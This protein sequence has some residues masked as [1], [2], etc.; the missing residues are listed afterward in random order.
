MKA[1]TLARLEQYVRPFMTRR[2]PQKVISTYSKGRLDF[3][4]KFK[5]ELP[6]K[7]YTPPTH[8]QQMLWGLRFQ[9][10]IMNSA[11]MFKNAE[12]YDIVLRQGAGAY[13]GGT[14]TWNARDGN[15]KEGIHLPFVPYPRSHSASNW[16]GLPN[17]GD[18]I[19]S[20][21]VLEMT[22][23]EG[24][25]IGWSLMGSPDFH[26]EE[27][28]ANLVKGMKLYEQAGV[29]FLEI[30]ESCP[31]TA[32]SQEEGLAQRLGYIKDNFLNKRQRQLPVIVKFSNDTPVEQIP[33]LMDLLFEQGYSGVNF[34]NTST[35]YAKRKEMIHPKEHA[36][37]DYF[38]THFGGGLSGKPLKESSLELCVKAVEYLKAGKPTQEFHVIRTGGIETTNDVKESLQ[39][40]ISLV[41]WFTG[42]FENFAKYG[43]R[44]YEKI[45]EQ[46]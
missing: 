13:L 36:L 31:N 19:N 6:E 16:L 22:H 41:Q 8:F 38:T 18:I 26:G 37:F 24:C 2:T 1:T 42:Y 30:N 33:K 20:Q 46:R 40:G 44:L 3:L 45:L 32:H 11:G 7:V 12:G 29:D 4:T 5:E 10:P 35:A 43:H 27:K 9:S 21:R 14:S 25:P 17:D 15:S 28:L 39:A 34:G 23:V